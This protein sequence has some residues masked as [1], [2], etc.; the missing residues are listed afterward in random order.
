M[1]WYSMAF[2]GIICMA[3]SVVCFIW[4]N[5]YSYFESGEI[6]DESFNS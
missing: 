4:Y 5:A 2:L 3:F 1:E 6:N